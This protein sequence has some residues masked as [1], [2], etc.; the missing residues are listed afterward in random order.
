[1]R[2]WSLPDQQ[3]STELQTLCEWLLQTTL[4]C[5]DRT[6]QAESQGDLL[7][8]LGKAKTGGEGSLAQRVENQ[9]ALPS[10]Q[11]PRPGGE[12][13]P[14][15]LPGQ[16][17]AQLQEA[18]CREALYSQ[19][20]GQTGSML[21]R[22]AKPEKGQSTSVRLVWGT[23][24]EWMSE[25]M[26]DS[27][28]APSNVPWSQI[29]LPPSCLSY[30]PFLLYQEGLCRKQRAQARQ[31]L[32]KAG[33]GPGQKETNPFWAPVTWE[34]PPGAS[35]CCPVLT[36]S[37]LWGFFFEWDLTCLPLGPPSACAGFHF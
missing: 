29:P 17:G 18:P 33:S 37:L 20:R 14:C 31:W 12:R 13:W 28:R 24:L 23:R 4:S 6:L 34:L 11:A 1:M 10:S 2:Q 32:P 21:C 9:G 27:N 35:H 16:P 3:A 26:N 25:W 19:D 22:Q 30:P 7:A 5:G 36:W 15:E 8:A